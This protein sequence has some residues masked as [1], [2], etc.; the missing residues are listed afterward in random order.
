MK[1][2][3]LK[4]LI[5]AILML[6]QIAAFAGLFGPSNMDDCVLEGMK[7]V[8]S[9]VAAGAIYRACKQKFP[10]PK[11]PEKPM[12][13][14]GKPRL[15][16]WDNRNLAFLNKIGIVS[17]RDSWTAVVTNKNSFPITGVYLANA[18]NGTCP[19]ENTYKEIYLYEGTIDQNTTGVVTGTGTGVKGS[20]CIVGI[21]GEWQPDINKFWRDTGLNLEPEVKP[22][23]KWSPWINK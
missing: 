6:N 17:W 12:I 8:Q 9:D 3:Y 5:L 14:S 4:T 20:Y 11:A 2:K 16:I 10:P 23:D 1:I 7:G 22:K 19:R 18:L 13:T 21:V 15:D